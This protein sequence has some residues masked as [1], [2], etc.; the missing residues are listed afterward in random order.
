MFDNTY[1]WHDRLPI[2]ALDITERHLRALVLVDL[3]VWVVDV[4]DLVDRYCKSSAS[5]TS[6]TSRVQRTLILD[7]DSGNTNCRVGSHLHR[8]QTSSLVALLAQL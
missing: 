8:S 3:E 1:L 4:W 2:F 6:N 5:Y 7:A